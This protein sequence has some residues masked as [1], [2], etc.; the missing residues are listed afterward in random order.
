[1]KVYEELGSVIKS[2]NGGSLTGRDA[3][4]E[5]YNVVDKLKSTG[6]SSD[7]IKYSLHLLNYAIPN[8]KLSNLIDIESI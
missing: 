8:L 5:L 4:H 7:L 3:I 1:M 6:V 2:I